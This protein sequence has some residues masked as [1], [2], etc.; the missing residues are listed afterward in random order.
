MR[1]E[2]DLSEQLRQHVQSLEA[3]QLKLE[4]QVHSLTSELHQVGH[5]AMSGRINC[6][7]NS[8]A[9]KIWIYHGDTSLQCDFVE[10]KCQLAV[11]L[12]PL[13]VCACQHEFAWLALLQVLL[14]LPSKQCIVSGPSKW[15]HCTSDVF[16]SS[17][18]L[19]QICGI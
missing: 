6:M 17:V 14:R 4:A 9:C 7:G 13:S 8:R 12:L 15:L 2:N 1:S 18:I 19:C 5:L 16:T 3:G 11:L 10:G